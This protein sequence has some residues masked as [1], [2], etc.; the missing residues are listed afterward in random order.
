MRKY[1]IG[2]DFGTL[3]GRTVL[4]D[5]GNGEEVAVAVHEYTHGVM[6]E[7]LPDG[8]PLAVDWAL[9]HPDDY[10]DVFRITIPQVMDMASVILPHAH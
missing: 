10:L 9:Q 1:A 4:V 7:K 2:V 5:T 3:S 8:T 6:D